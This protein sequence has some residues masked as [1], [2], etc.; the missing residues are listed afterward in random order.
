M[1]KSMAGK[2]ALVTGA[3]RGIGR[4]CAIELATQ[5]VTVA[6]A[7]VEEPLATMKAVSD[8]DGKGSAFTCD[9]A[10]ESSV[11]RL[12]EK[13]EQE[14]GGLDILVHCAGVMD[15]RPLLETR[16]QDFQRVVDINLTGT[17]IVGR[18]AIRMMQH[19]GGR[20]ILIASDLSYLGRETCSAYVASKHGVLGLTRSWAKEFAP[21]ILVNAICPG[22][23]D[24]PMLDADNMSAEWRALELGIPLQRFG[25]AGEIAEMAVFLASDKA[26][27]I[28]GQGIGVNGGSVMP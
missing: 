25:E 10:D 19:G 27:F 5:G 18:E 24:T 16:I 8:L 26:R 14:S 7:D 1:L 13:I 17:F 15:K 28:T 22:P 23:I 2:T 3:A 20:I 12:F 6:C 21:H 9:V 11:S 4:A